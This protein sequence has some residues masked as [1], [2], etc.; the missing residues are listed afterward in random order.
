MART[1]MRASPGLRPA[2]GRARVYRLASAFSHGGPICAKSRAAGP[3]ATPRLRS[4]HWSGGTPR[5]SRFRRRAVRCGG[6]RRGRTPACRR[7][8]ARM[9]TGSRPRTARTGPAMRSPGRRPDHER[10]ADLRG[11][12]LGLLL[13]PAALQHVLDLQ[14]QPEGQ[15]PHV[16][17][18]VAGTGI[19]ACGDE[20]LYLRS[21]E[22]V[23]APVMAAAEHRRR[24]RPQVAE[25]DL[26]AGRRR[27][28]RQRRRAPGGDVRRR[29]VMISAKLSGRVS[30]QRVICRV[31]G[32]TGPGGAA[33]GHRAES[34]QNRDLQ[35]LSCHNQPPLPPATVAARSVTRRHHH[36][37][38][39][40][41][42]SC[43]SQFLVAAARS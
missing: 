16:D 28:W 32:T 36:W 14:A 24:A 34:S 27:R 43:Q 12:D 3:P 20:R 11:D 22:P 6:E 30:S 15:A 1:P 4:R 7:G 38:A 25:A 8:S 40:S 5:P 2:V 37:S 42:N 18:L 29:W 23:P 9:A 10:S 35:Y 31:F 17:A 39:R 21:S 19:L 33:R 41:R 13:V 26:A